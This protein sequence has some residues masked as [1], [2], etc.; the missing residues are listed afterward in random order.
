M[1]KRR[2]NNIKDNERNLCQNVL[3]IENTDSDLKVHALLVC[4]RLSFQTLLQTRSI[5]RNNTKNSL[6]KEYSF[7]IRVQTTINHISI[8][9]FPQHQRQRKCFFRARAEKG[10][11]QHI[12]ASSAVWVLNDNGRLVN[13]ITRLAAIVVKTVFPLSQDC[14]TWC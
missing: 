7:S 8:C 11:A 5:C 1:I 9:F 14:M 2:R 10:I 12:N 6:G 3:T 4:V 13:Q